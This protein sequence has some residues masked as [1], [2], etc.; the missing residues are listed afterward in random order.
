MAKTVIEAE[1][2]TNVGAVSKDISFMGVSVNSVSAAFTKMGVMAKSAFASVKAGIISTGIGALVVAVVALFTYFTKTQRGADALAKAMAGLGAAVDVV[3][4]SMSKLG[5][6]IIFAF[7]APEA[8]VKDLWESIKTNLVNRLE[9]LIELFKSLGTVAKA[10]FELDWD[11]AIQGAKDYGS[12]MLQIGTGLDAEQQQAL[13]DAAKKLA[14]EVEEET[15]AAIRLE[16]IRQGIRRKEMEFS[17]VQAQTRQDIA[18]ARLLAMNETLEQTVRLKAVEEVMKKELEMTE[19]LLKLQEQKVA[20]A[21]EQLGLGE[22]MIE[23]EEALMAL[24]VELINLQTQSVMSQKRLMTEVETLQLEIKAKEKADTKKTADAEKARIAKE[25]LDLQALTEWNLTRIEG[26]T[27][28]ELKIRM[29]AAEAADKKLTSMRKENA[30]AGIK[31]EIEGEKQRA[32]AILQVQYDAELEELKQHENFLKLK[33]ELDI[34]YDHLREAATDA[35]DKK[36]K[37]KDKE[38]ADYK[39]DLAMQAFQ[40]VGSHLDAS[41]DEL[42]SNYS[43][44]KRL[45]EENGQDTTAIDEK[46]EAKRKVLAQKQKDFQ[47]AEA[48]ITTYRMAS[49]AYLAGTKVPGVG[50]ALGPIAAAVALAAGLANV[51]SILSQDVGAGA[52]GAAAAATS[53]TPAPE[54]MS[55]SFELGGGQEVEPLQAYV[56][57]DDITDNQDALALIRRRATI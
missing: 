56:V 53:G 47:V 17:K 35:A 41:M 10:A 5:D 34:K 23:D 49:E 7:E 37:Q 44:E 38:L 21:T 6:T 51:R 45:A 36:Q 27:D 19:G 39:E 16:G 50:L 20:A 32:L 40:T 43:K 48:L 29:K 22:S 4:D 57:S 2:K 18:A 26:E 28:A 25:K 42:E 11:A 24:E 54:M 33:E 55:G 8:A 15:K 31:D 30:L 1:V 9:G 14:K 46:Y 3:V 13:I 12:A 52:G